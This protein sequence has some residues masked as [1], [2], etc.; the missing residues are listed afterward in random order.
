MD[1]RSSILDL[2]LIRRNQ[3]LVP[4]ALKYIINGMQSPEFKLRHK[5]E[6]N[7]IALEMSFLE[8][9]QNNIYDLLSPTTRIGQTKPSLIARSDAQGILHVANLTVSSLL[10]R[11]V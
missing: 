3:G 5:D 7:K 2:Q 4:R 9:Y 10:W 6:L 1:P 11:D 8:D